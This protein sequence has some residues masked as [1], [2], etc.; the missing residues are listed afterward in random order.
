MTLHPFLCFVEKIQMLRKLLHIAITLL[1]LISINGFTIH[2]HYCHDVLTGVSVFFDVDNCCESSCAHCKN[3]TISCRLDLDIL[4]ANAQ[5]I[6]EK[7][8]SSIILYGLIQTRI[9]YTP[10]PRT[11]T[12]FPIRKIKSNSMHGNAMLQSFRC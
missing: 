7:I 4:S 8:Q 10:E 1:L 5:N 9:I 11:S 2:K 12:L 6:P 3:E